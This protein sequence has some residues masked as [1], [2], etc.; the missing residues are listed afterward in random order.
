M[1]RVSGR[2]Q[3]HGMQGAAGADIQRH[4]AELAAD[5][6]SSGAEDGKRKRRVCPSFKMRRDKLAGVLAAKQSEAGQLLAANLGLRLRWHALHLM[7]R[8]AEEVAEHRAAIHTAQGGERSCDGIADNAVAGTRAQPQ[9]Q[10]PQLSSISGISSTR[11]RPSA[12]GRMALYETLADGFLAKL[13]YLAEGARLLHLDGCVPGACRFLLS[14]HQPH[15]LRRACDM[16]GQT[17]PGRAAAARTLCLPACLPACLWAR[18]HVCSAALVWHTAL[19]SPRSV[20][21]PR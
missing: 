12:A 8:T 9:Q 13:P 17:H 16:S 6:D 7:A 14:G 21:P 4:H 5:P 11:P 19:R 20:A 3:A 10:A 2:A 18:R 15:Q 1:H